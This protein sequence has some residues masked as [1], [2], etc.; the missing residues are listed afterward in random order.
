MML[1]FFGLSD[2]KI[3]IIQL[4]L[5]YFGYI[6]IYFFFVQLILWICFFGYNDYFLWVRNGIYYLLW[7]FL[8]IIYVVFGMQGYFCF[9]LD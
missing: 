9:V 6:I 8:N 3:G 7:V 1:R 5:V 2:R 4:E